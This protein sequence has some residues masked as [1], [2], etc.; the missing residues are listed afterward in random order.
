MNKLL[1]D[2]WESLVHV[3]PEVLLCHTLVSVASVQKRV[4]PEWR[5]VQV[6]EHSSMKRHNLK[7]VVA[8]GNIICLEI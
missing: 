6:L 8:R 5:E 1:A 4:S 7:G 2:A 3:I